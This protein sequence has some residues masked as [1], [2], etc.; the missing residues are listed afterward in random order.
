MIE[1]SW[2]YLFYDVALIAVVLLPLALVAALMNGR[3]AAAMIYALALAVAICSAWLVNRV[4]KLS[5]RTYW[6]SLDS[7]QAGL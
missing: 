4:S 3:S 7:R 5:L 6:R 1:R 2:A